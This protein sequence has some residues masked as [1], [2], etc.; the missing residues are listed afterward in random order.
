[1]SKD[2]QSGFALYFAIIIMSILLAVVF[3]ISTITLA[4]IRSIR[5][6]GDS[7]IAFYAADTGAERALYEGRFGAPPP[8]T[9]FEGTLSNGASYK[10]TIVSITSPDCHGSWYCIESVGSYRG[11]KRAVRITR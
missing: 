6:M 3:S 8:G 4:Q 7:I 1:M 2:S 9:I 5:R 11:S 10:V